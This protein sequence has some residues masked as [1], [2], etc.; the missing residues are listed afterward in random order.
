[1]LRFT[2]FLSL[3]LMVAGVFLSVEQANAAPKRKNQSICSKNGKL[4]VRPRCPRKAE[5]IANLSDLIGPTGP[6]GPLSSTLPSGV[7][8]RGFYTTQNYAASSSSLLIGMISYNFSLSAVPT[9]HYI[10]FNEEPPAE[11]PGTVEQPEAAAGHLCVYE[12]GRLNVSDAVVSVIAGDSAPSNFGARVAATS[13]SAG[14][15]YVEG[16]WA[17]T[18]P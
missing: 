5:R 18:A 10:A 1:M 16:T 8:M 9:A 12:D 17:V 15:A 13:T 11:C 2:V 4:S 6:T 7:T 3:A 14:T